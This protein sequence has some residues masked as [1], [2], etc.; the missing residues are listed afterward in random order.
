MVSSVSSSHFDQLRNMTV[1]E[2]APSPRKLAAILSADIA[3]Y[4]ALMSADEE[5]TFRKL[6]LVRKAILPIIERFGGRIIDLAGDGIL[7]EFASAV[8]AVESAAA[9]QQCM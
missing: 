1:P 9:V 4:S 3:G 8:R 6:G 5:S 2:S 7:A